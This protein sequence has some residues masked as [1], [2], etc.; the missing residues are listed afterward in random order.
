MDDMLNIFSGFNLFEPAIAILRDLLQNGQVWGVGSVYDG[1]KPIKKALKHWG[2]DYW[3]II[4]IPKEMWYTVSTPKD[5]SYKTFEALDYYGIV[6]HASPI[7][8][9][10][11]ET[12]KEVG[13]WIFKHFR[14]GYC[15]AKIREEAKNCP[16]CGGPWQ[17]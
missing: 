10:P 12:V 14:C 1:K 3:G 5:Q 9:T 13:F 2:V 11:E 8:C 7:I 4:P 15:N 17:L 16:E 6:I